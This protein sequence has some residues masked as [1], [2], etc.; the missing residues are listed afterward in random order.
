[1]HGKIHHQPG[2]IP[3]IPVD[4]GKELLVT[5]PGSL[6]C[7]YNSIFQDFFFLNSTLFSIEAKLTR[8][9]WIMFSGDYQ[10][11]DSLGNSVETLE[12][13]QN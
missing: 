10:P 4:P 1:M 6:H 8:H 2:K 5:I 12:A 9:I 3:T 7:K 13:S 11:W